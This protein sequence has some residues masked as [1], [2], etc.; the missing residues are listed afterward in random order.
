MEDR[1]EELLQTKT[2]DQLNGEEKKL[3]EEI[4]GS[5]QAFENMKKIDLAL[6][7]KPAHILPE[8]ARLRFLKKHFQETHQANSVFV[9]LF[10]AK[11]PSYAVMVLVVLC[12]MSAWLLGRNSRDTKVIS[13]AP[14]VNQDTVYLASRPDTVFIEKVVY[15]NVYRERPARSVVTV[16]NHSSSD[17]QQEIG[18]NMKEKSELDYLLVSGSE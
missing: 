9:K 1:I 11:V 16:V 15:K 18:V 14:V 8:S 7:E 17:L 10:A 2:W 6:S 3:V 12:V 13:T 4:L 5:R